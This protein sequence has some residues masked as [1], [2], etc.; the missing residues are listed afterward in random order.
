MFMRGI[1]R[2]WFVNTIGIILIILIVF[3]TTMSLTIQTSTYTSMT[4]VM[5]GR[6]VELLNVLSS[7][8]ANRKSSAAELSAA[9]REYIENFPDKNSMEVMYINPAGQIVI[10]STGFAP[11]SPQEMFDYEEA[12]ASPDDQAHWVGKLE[13]G[14]KVMALT[15]IVRDENH[16]ILGSLRYVI[17]L[18]KADHQIALIVTTLI[19]VGI[20]IMLII[21]ITGLVFMRSIIIPIRQVSETASEISR[22]DFDVRIDPPGKRKD[23]EIGQ[24]CDSINDMASEL[25]ASEK[26]KNDFISSVSHELRTPLTSIK[27]WAETLQTSDDPVMTEKGMDVIIRESERLTGIV[28]ELLD[29]SRLQSGRMQMNFQPVDI[30]NEL[31]EIVYMFSDRAKNEE[32][33]L[34][35]EEKGELPI[36]TGDPNRLTQVFVN[37][38]D[39]ALKYMNSGGIVE[40]IAEST[41]DNINLTFKDN[42]YGIPEEHLQNIKKKFYKANQ[43]VRGSGIGLAV[44]DEIVALHSGKLQIDSKEGVGT[45]VTITLPINQTLESI[46]TNPAN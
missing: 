17:S 18:E 15:R 19:V 37:I 24:L 6:I 11:D 43:M 33:S 44:A 13:T 27:G 31:S 30:S 4:S 35:L 12:M 20:I 32:K 7:S 42:G 29:F 34:K 40:I 45:T 3:I 39:N 1:S 14:E 46:K 25:G 38:M 5:Q 36:I 26:M 22:G 10:T 16:N 21:I 9:S 2:R 41:D 8:S 28:E 23:D